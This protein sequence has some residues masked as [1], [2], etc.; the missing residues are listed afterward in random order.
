MKSVKAILWQRYVSAAKRA[1][2]SYTKI[3]DQMALVCEYVKTGVAPEGYID[4]TPNTSIISG[5]VDVEFC[6]IRS[7]IV[8]PFLAIEDCLV[9][10]RGK[11]FWGDLQIINA[12][13]MFFDMIFTG[14]IMNRETS[15][16][17]FRTSMVELLSGN[18]NL[19]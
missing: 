1:G 6:G 2:W 4:D 14:R 13:V 10:F 12:F 9:E 11:E 7:S 8:V 17:N 3:L 19:R 5:V 15:C 16:D 18:M